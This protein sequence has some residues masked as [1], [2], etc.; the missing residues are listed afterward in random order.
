MRTE[1]RTHR[2]VTYDEDLDQCNRGYVVVASE[3]HDRADTAE[4]LNACASRTRGWLGSVVMP[5]ASANAVSREA[6][7]R[8]ARGR[9]CGDA[10]MN[11]HYKTRVRAGA[12]TP[13]FAVEPFAALK[14]C[15]NDSILRTRGQ[16]AGGGYTRGC[17]WGCC[18]TSWS[19][20]RL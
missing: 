8:G 9:R 19:G 17:A 12:G 10:Q 20:E 18:G 2:T 6:E 14:S 4:Q 13:L 7:P 3:V 5:I 1:D 11:T 15:G 16:H